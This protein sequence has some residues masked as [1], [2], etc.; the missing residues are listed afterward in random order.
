[1]AGSHLYIEAGSCEESRI[2]KK[3]LYSKTFQG[4]QPLYNSAL[5][6]GV[7]NVFMDRLCGNVE[8]LNCNQDT[9]S[10]YFFCFKVLFF[11]IGGG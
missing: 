5:K 10:F 9:H 6:H 4:I 11:Q 3:R 8:L 2:N 7:L 1:M